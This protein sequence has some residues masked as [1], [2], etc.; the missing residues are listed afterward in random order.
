[1]R[2][3]EATSFHHDRSAASSRHLD[4]SAAQWSDL[5]TLANQHA[6]TLAHA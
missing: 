2:L 3:G 1:M 5:E 6:L 4:E